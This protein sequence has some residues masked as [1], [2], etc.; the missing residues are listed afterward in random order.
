MGKKRQGPDPIHKLSQKYKTPKQVQDF[1]RK[2]PY[3]RR[4]TLH[5]AETSAKKKTAHCFEAA[6]LAA[7][8]LER[9]GY[10][11]LV[12]SFE[13]RDDLD[14]V[15]YVFQEKGKWGAIAR[16]RDEGLHGRPPI[17]K[18]LRSL[19][20]SYYEPY[21]DKT[22]EILAFQIAHLDDSGADWRFSSRSVWKA[23]NY[24]LEIPHQSI[25]QSR[26]RYKKLKSAYL[27]NGPMKR[28]KFWW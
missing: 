16:S 20:L 1:L 15:I 7:A 11:P 4:D 26:S 19:A 2:F 17:F 24:L 28:Q 6:I 10:P 21:V 18:S 5:S 9:H 14:H 22:G 3:N 23:E 13:S 8:I 27:K 25:R 12:I